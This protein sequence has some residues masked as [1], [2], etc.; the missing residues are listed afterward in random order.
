MR[1]LL[2]IAV[3][4]PLLPICFFRPFLGVLL[5]TIMSY[6]SPERYAFGFTHSLQVG[7]MIATPTIIGMIIGR[8]L[9]IPP[10]SRETLLLGLLWLWFAIT[11]LNVYF[12][13]LLIHHLT[14]TLTRFGE[15]SRSLIMVFVALILTKDKVKL[16]WWFLVTA[17]CFAFLSFKALRFGLITSGESRAYGPPGTELADNNG[18]GLALNMSLPMFL[19]LAGIEESKALRIFLYLAFVAGL[20]GV[21]LSYSRGAFVGLLFLMLVIAMQSK[22]KVRAVFGLLI[23]CVILLMAAPKQWID[24]MQ[25]ITTAQKTDPSAQERFNSWNFAAHLAYEFPILGG[26]FKTFT[27]PLY[28]RYGLS[29]L[30]SEGKQWG[31]HSIYFQMLAEHGF[32]GLFLFL[33]LMVSCIWS[34]YKVKRTFRRIESDHFLVI[35]SNIIIASLIAYAASGAF[36]GFAYFD[37]F[38]QVVATTIILKYLAKKEMLALAESDDEVTEIEEQNAFNRVC[39]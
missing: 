21:G 20:V 14:D 10:I 31:P 5:W 3:L 32:P 7:Y 8:K 30:N 25:T 34:A 4:F 6:L 28:Q 9:N 11:T 13:S 12:S 33:A 16:R 36:L 26:G 39:Q 35:Y 15:V 27:D 24:R 29:L 38:Y 37:L 18:F 2:F 17:F 23:I 1:D 22:R 19:Y